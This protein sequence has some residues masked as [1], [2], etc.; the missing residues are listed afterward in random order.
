MLVFYLLIFKNH[1]VWLVIIVRLWLQ[2]ELRSFPS[3]S[4]P[5]SSLNNTG[6]TYALNDLHLRSYGRQ[7]FPS[8]LDSEHCSSPF[9]SLPRIRA[10]LCKT[11]SLP[12]GPW[13][14]G[15]LWSW[16]QA[17][18]RGE[19]SLLLVVGSSSQKYPLDSSSSF[20]QLVCCSGKTIR[21]LGE[22]GLW[23]LAATFS[24]TFTCCYGFSYIY[25]VYVQIFVR[26]GARERRDAC[27]QCSGSILITAESNFS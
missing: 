15:N 12:G 1:L 27:A 4:V 21:G 25:K 5:L 18:S 14:G 20:A 11:P 9:P 2:N 13:G 23:I 22:S 3:I 24:E 10:P 16:L 7:S 8:W 26:V 17:P 6:I 19:P